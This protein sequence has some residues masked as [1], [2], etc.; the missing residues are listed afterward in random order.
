MF[1][2]FRFEVEGMFNLKKEN[3]VIILSFFKGCGMVFT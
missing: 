1:L 3:S 2:N